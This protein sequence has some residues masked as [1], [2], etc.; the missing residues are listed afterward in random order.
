MGRK[1]PIYLDF[2]AHAL[3]DSRVAKLLADAYIEYD[4][5]PHSSHA[6]GEMALRAV[7]DA[8]KE[9]ADLL[10]AASGEIIFTSGA[11]EA[12][13]LAIIGMSDFLRESKRPRILVSAGEHP[14][15]LAAAEFAAPGMVTTIPLTSD[16][17]VDLPVLEAMISEDVGMV[18]I[19]AANHEIGTIQPLGEISQMLRSR[20]VLFHSDLAQA[21]A[22]MRVDAEDLDLASISAHKMGGPVG[23][24][25]LYIRR[26]LRRRLKPRALGGGQESGARAGT[27]PVPLCVAF[28]GAS[29]LAS[30]ERTLTVQRVSYLRDELLDRL[31]TAG[32]VRVNGGSPRLPGNLNLSFDGVDGE[33]LVV[34]VGKA[35][36][37][38]TGSA[39]TSA[40]L[41]PSH[42]LKAIGLTDRQAEGALRM[43]I[44][45]STTAEEIADA[46]DA[47]LEAVASLRS[48]RRRVA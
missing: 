21:C 20:G 33:A 47:I 16:G 12:N 43:G 31:Q 41:E 6:A 27:V 34:A 45:P 30:A 23:I 1:A 35:V 28:G 48:L 39:C 13:N 2:N 32:G 38:S 19:A 5:N 17:V 14:S 15:V 25:A 42:V 37:V 7:E 18:S 22:W 8:R 11:T 3:L 44:G 26:P 46:A 10:G 29:R 36:Y 40:S 4:A 24:G 9:V